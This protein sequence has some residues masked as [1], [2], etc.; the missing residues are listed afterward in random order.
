MAS[1]GRIALALA[2]GNRNFSGADA[3]TLLRRGKLWCGL[4][5]HDR[6]SG[7]H[8]GGAS[9]W[10]KPGRRE[11]PRAWPAPAL[12]HDPDPSQARIPRERGPAHAVPAAVVAS[13][14]LSFSDANLT[15][16]P[17][18]GLDRDLRGRNSG[19]GVAGSCSTLF[20]CR[21]T[22]RRDPLCSM[23]AAIAARGG[24]KVDRADGLL[25]EA[26]IISVHSP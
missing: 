22:R 15:G 9:A 4:N 23:P 8:G 19:T 6:M 2:S 24:E 16:P 20:G 14:D 11:C 17:A 26:D 10:L 21:R 1:R 25:R 18:V 12:R 7:L 13:R 3:P 5:G